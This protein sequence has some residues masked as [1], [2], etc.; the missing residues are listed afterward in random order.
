MIKKINRSTAPVETFVIMLARCL[1]CQVQGKDPSVDIT[2]DIGEDDD[3]DEACPAAAADEDAD[4]DGSAVSSSTSV[5]R[6][7]TLPPCEL[8]R[9]SEITH[10][11]TTTLAS[12]PIRRDRLATAIEQDNYIRQLIDLFHCCEDLDDLDGLH[13]LYAVFKSLFMLNKTTL[14]ETLLSSEVI[15]DV[16][17][18]LEYDP[19]LPEPATHREF[20]TTGSRL[21]QVIPH[22]NWFQFL[23]DWYP[24]SHLLSCVIYCK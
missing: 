7:L 20:L 8:T 15:M 5:S 18:A 2:Q 13:Q 24:G 6:G 17:G 16:I 12:T 23:F 14:L 19:L 3:E 1:E 22:Y 9:L 4:T 10:L 11:F 21:R